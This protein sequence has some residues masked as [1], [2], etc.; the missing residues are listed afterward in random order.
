M[1]KIVSIYFLLMS[2]IF[3]ADEIEIDEYKVGNIFSTTSNSMLVL[4]H[5][6]MDAIQYDRVKSFGSSD[7]FSLRELSVDG[8]DIYKLHR[9]DKFQIS[10]SLRK[11]KVLKVKLLKDKPRRKFYYAVTDSIKH[12]AELISTTPS[13]KDS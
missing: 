1:K 6:Q 3:L 11:G 9:G 2:C 7:I 5:Y 10:E 8:R 13:N 4:Y 12:H